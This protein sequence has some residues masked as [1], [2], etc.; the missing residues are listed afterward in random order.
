MAHLTRGW[1]VMLNA[2][3][4]ASFESR[5]AAYKPQPVKGAVTTATSTSRSASGSGHSA[6]NTTCASPAAHHCECK[7]MPS[8][9]AEVG[10]TG[11]ERGEDR[12]DAASAWHP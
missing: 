4:L 2:G 5:R 11:A 10:R 6:F 3:E 7:D 12:R 1:L 9:D 8:L